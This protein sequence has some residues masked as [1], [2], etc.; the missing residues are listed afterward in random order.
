M[1]FVEAAYLNGSPHSDS[2]GHAAK[3]GK[4]SRDSS[5][6]WDSTLKRNHTPQW[7]ECEQQVVFSL[8]TVPYMPRVKKAEML[9]SPIASVMP[10]ARI[11][12]D[13]GIILLKRAD[14]AK[15]LGEG[16]PSIEVRLSRDN[17]PMLEA[18]V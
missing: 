15:S 1:I 18:A 13:E 9:V 6:R 3:V 2:I 7:K 17:T 14:V 5:W 11:L 4:K 12:W 10:H 16:E 8:K